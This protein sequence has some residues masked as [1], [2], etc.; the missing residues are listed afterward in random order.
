MFLGGFGLHLL[1]LRGVAIDQIDELQ[2][3]L[4]IRCKTVSQWIYR[5]NRELRH[6]LANF[7]PVDVY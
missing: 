5:L 7:L 2:L 1:K 6:E 4:L 3:K